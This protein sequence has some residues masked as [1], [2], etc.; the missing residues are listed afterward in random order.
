MD[1]DAEYSD[2][3][4]DD[5]DLARL[6]QLARLDREKFF[7][8][9]PALARLYHD[10]VICVALCQ[11]AALHYVDGCNG[12]KDFDVWTFF[13]EHAA[14]RFPRRPVTHADFGPSKFGKNPNDVGYVGRRVDFLMRG[15]ACEPEA[16]TVTVLCEYLSR[17]L[18]KSAWELAKKAA[19]LLEPSTLRGLKIWPLEAAG[20][21]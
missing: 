2:A 6:A 3:K 13:A 20:R 12:V 9:N 19:I 10:R 4:I 11:G 15:V 17:P 7:A 8:R 18:T 14:H 5:E 1:R 16:E 21:E